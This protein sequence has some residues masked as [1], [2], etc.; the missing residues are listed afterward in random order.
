M[1]SFTC[2]TFCQ[3]G[4][5]TPLPTSLALHLPPFSFVSVAKATL[6]VPFFFPWRTH[7]ARRFSLLVLPSSQRWELPYRRFFAP[8]C[9]FFL[10]RLIFPSNRR[11]S[12]A[13][14]NPAILLL[15]P[16]FPNQHLSQSL[17]RR[18]SF[19]PHSPSSPCWIYISKSNN[20]NLYRRT[21]SFTCPL[22]IY[23]GAV[24]PSLPFLRFLSL[25]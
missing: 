10:Q 12:H 23:F 8:F 16:R 1:K 6:S 24:K 4:K 20:T 19:Y 22:S 5:F 2:T 11:T 17:F 15:T 14:Q 21:G 18:C 13:A 7:L 25:G 9:A 3:F